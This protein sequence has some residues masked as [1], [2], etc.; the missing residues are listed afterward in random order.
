VVKYPP[1]FACLEKQAGP[2]ACAQEE[3]AGPEK[4]KKPKQWSPM[5]LLLSRPSTYATGCRTEP[6]RIRAKEELL[7]LKS[8][9][10]SLLLPRPRKT[11]SRV[12]PPVAGNVLYCTEEREPSSPKNKRHCCCLEVWSA[13]EP[14]AAGRDRRVREKSRHGLLLLPKK[15]IPRADLCS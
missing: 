5:P 10:S 2:V 11:R 4:Q 12:L 3:D 9:K 13:R 1:L 15:S 6:Q 14:H 7:S 8:K